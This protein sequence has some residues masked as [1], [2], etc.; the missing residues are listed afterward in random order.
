MADEVLGHQG[1]VVAFLSLFHLC[2]ANTNIGGILIT[3]ASDV[4][5]MIDLHTHTILSDGELLPTEL[6]RRAAVHGYTAI[7]IT[8]HVDFS[9]LES[10]LGSLKRTKDVGKE[11]DIEVLIGVEPTHIPPTKI[12]KI[13]TQARQLG[14]ELIVV[15]GETLIEPVA[16]GTNSAAAHLE[17][18]DIIAH[19]GLITIED[20]EA[21]R[22]NDICLEITSRRGHCLT[23]G[24]V[25]R[26]ATKVGA[27]LVVN[28]DAHNPTDLITKQRALEIARGA[29]LDEKEADKVINVNPRKFLK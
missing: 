9:N 8:D 1:P 13:V 14:A 16:P 23:N 12:E 28:T 2:V 20:V 24:H 21:A 29:G 18:V 19:P 27:T 22:D 5:T 6:V 11:W 7:G 26:M 4:D 3:F 17:D 10:V 15:H 25:A